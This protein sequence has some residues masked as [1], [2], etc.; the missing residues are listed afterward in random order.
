MGALAEPLAASTPPP[1]REP[2]PL[3]AYLGSA[4]IDENGDPALDVEYELDAGAQHGGGGQTE[5]RGLAPAAADSKPPPPPPP[6][7]KRPPLV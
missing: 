7:R 3:S 4:G 6:P 2:R 5:R 1:A